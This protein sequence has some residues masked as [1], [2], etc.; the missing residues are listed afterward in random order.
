MTLTNKKI[1]RARRIK[2]IQK[3]C[4]DKYSNSDGVSE[5][6][7]RISRDTSTK[8]IFTKR[9]IHSKRRKLPTEKRDGKSIVSNL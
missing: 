1:S 4:T 5:N 7:N 2:S 8:F 3:Q 9:S 6:V